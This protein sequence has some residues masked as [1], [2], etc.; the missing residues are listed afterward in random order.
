MNKNEALKKIDELKKFVEQCDQNEDFV[1]IDYSVI[2]K[3]KFDKYGVK[4]FQIAKRKARKENG[5][6]WND[7]NFYDAKKE[8][9]KMGARL[10]Q[11]NEMLLLL[12]A[13]KEKYPNDASCDHKEFLGIE[14]LSYQED[15]CYEW[16]D[17]LSVIPFLRGGP[18][19]NSS[20]AGAFAL[21]LDSSA[22]STN[23][24]VGFRCARGI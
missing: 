6:V 5:E 4:P 17:S 13:Y 19:Y 9:E 14:E 15:V 3:E 12:D 11:L 2:P 18:W 24:S 10:P 20:D 7:I 8:A 21:A 16:I 22:G 1:T 23:L